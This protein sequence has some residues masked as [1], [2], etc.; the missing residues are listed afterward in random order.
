MSQQSVPLMSFPPVPPPV[1]RA[2]DPYI[3]MYC[4]R[5]FLT[6]FPKYFYLEGHVVRS[7]RVQYS[8]RQRHTLHTVVGLSSRCKTRPCPE[9]PRGRVL[10]PRALTMAPPEVSAVTHT[11]LRMASWDPLRVHVF[12]YERRKVGLGG[13]H[14]LCVGAATRSLR[15]HHHHSGRVSTH[16]PSFPPPPA[17]HS[18]PNVSKSD[19]K[20]VLQFYFL[21]TS[22][23]SSEICDASV[24]SLGRS[25]LASSAQFSVNVSD[26]RGLR[27]LLRACDRHQDVTVPVCVRVPAQSVSCCR[28]C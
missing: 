23:I 19:A 17:G 8:H 4:S 12:H 13:T 24:C 20:R 3:D 7:A 2:C 5:M 28:T 9:A 22:L 6:Q 15:R 26:R 18:L 25:L 16:T 1:R 11:A 14:M 21:L 27:C 10:L